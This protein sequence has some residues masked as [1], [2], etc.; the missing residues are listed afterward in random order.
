MKITPKSILAGLSWA[1]T[2]VMMQPSLASLL[3]LLINAGLMSLIVR[4]PSEKKT[5]A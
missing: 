1:G 3:V 5:H 4:L 2:A